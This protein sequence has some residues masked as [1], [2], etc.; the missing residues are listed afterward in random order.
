MPVNALF[1]GAKNNETFI[2]YCLERSQIICRGCVTK[3][4]HE[5]SNA[6]GIVRIVGNPVCA[7]CKR[8]LLQKDPGDSGGSTHT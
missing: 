4:E 8:D 3:A 2:G 1:W 6:G 7:R 5:E